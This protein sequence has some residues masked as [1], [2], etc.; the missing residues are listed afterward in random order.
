MVRYLWGLLPLVTTQVITPKTAL[1][2]LAHIQVLQELKQRIERAAKPVQNQKTDR[3]PT[4]AHV[5][6]VEAGGLDAG[7]GSYY[8]SRIIDDQKS[9]PEIVRKAI[10]REKELC[11][12]YYVFYH[13]QNQVFRAFQDFLKELYTLVSIHAPLHEFEFLRMWHKAEKTFDTQEFID[14]EEGWHP[15]TVSWN[16]HRS[17]LVKNMLC[18]NLSLLGG[19]TGERTFDYFTGGCSIS[20]SSIDGIMN[21]LFNDFGFDKKY[22]SQIDTINKSFVTPTGNLMQIFIPKNKVDDYVY[23]SQPFGTPHRQKIVD[24][25]FDDKKKRHTKISPILD[26]YY[27]GADPITIFDPLQARILLSQDCMLNPESGVKIFRYTKATDQEIQKYKDQVKAVAQRVFADAIEKGTFK[28]IS[29]T[30]LG[31]LLKY[32]PKNMVSNGKN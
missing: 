1:P 30:C 17:D 9:Q 6:A 25:V 28:N 4:Y 2:V 8:K 12:D 13:G 7:W 29:N 22:L 26:A 20:L 16:D 3:I 31:R 14:K 23:L 27:K 32:L 18:V 10:E 5:K 15:G 21:E 19:F 11:S 24:D